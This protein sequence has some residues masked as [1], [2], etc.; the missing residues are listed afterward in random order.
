[1]R[2]LIHNAR[3]WVTQLGPTRNWTLQRQVC[4][5]HWVDCV[6]DANY[7]QKRTH[8]YRSQHKYPIGYVVRFVRDPDEE[9][10]VSP[11]QAAYYDTDVTVVSHEVDP[12]P[13]GY[14]VCT[15]DGA[16]IFAWETE[17]QQRTEVSDPRRKP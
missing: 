10:T 7:P 16:K 11:E 6:L 12:G 1:M 8:K 3:T 15:W 4:P 2:F 17:L 5:A 13:D 14:K 9:H